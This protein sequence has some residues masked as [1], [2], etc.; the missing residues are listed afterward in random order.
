MCPNNGRGTG[1]G[2]AWGRVLHRTLLA[3]CVHRQRG[4]E[5]E[6]GAGTDRQE[7]G[8]RT[9]K[10]RGEGWGR[11]GC[12]SYSVTRRACSE[13]LARGA[14]KQR[15]MEEGQE[16]NTGGGG[17]SAP[18]G[19]EEGASA[20]QN[21]CTVRAKTEGARVGREDGKRPAKQ[22]ADQSRGQQGRRLAGEG[23]RGC[24]GQRGR[25]K[26]EWNRASRVGG[27][28]R[29]AKKGKQGKVEE[30]AAHSGVQLACPVSIA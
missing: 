19:T 10:C 16:Q 30:L 6:G 18:R 23:C 27:E 26:G 13:E 20:L 9:A 14:H 15:E 1:E 24:A 17:A 4:Q 25:A 11:A 8:C 3:Q 2:E 7:V 29:R 21:V 12:A 28:S 22:R 5:K